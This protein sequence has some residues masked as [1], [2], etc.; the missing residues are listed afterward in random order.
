VIGEDELGHLATSLFQF[1]L[2]TGTQRNH[3]SNLAF[4]YNFCDSFLRNPLA[5]SPIYI[6]RYIAWL[7][8]RGTVAADNL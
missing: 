7:C 2:S 1:A 3:G 4:F 5:V 6:A 8:H